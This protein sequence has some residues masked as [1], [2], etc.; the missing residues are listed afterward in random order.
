MS[1]G[2]IKKIMN[3][4]PLR[5]RIRIKPKKYVVTAPVSDPGDS[6]DPRVASSA[7]SMLMYTTLRDPERCIL[8]TTTLS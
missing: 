7:I 3:K 5:I 1:S 4:A 6:I 8:W 2:L